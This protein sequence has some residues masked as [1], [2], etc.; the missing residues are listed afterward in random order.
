MTEPVVVGVSSYGARV[1]MVRWAAGEA[2][3]RGTELWLVT[4]HRDRHLPVDADRDA[5]LRTIADSWP[6]LTVRTEVAVGR[7]A[8]VLREF[9]E[10]AA[11]L[12]VGADDVSPFTEAITGSVPGDLL[13][14]AP[15]PLAVVPRREWTT[16]ASTPVVVALDGQET[17]QAALAYAFAAADRCDSPLTVLRFLA[18]GTAEPADRTLMGFRGLYHG[19]R[20]TTEVSHADPA[21]ELVA[22]SRNAAQLVLGSRGRGRLTSGLFGSVSRTLIRKAGCPVVVGRAPAAAGFRDPAAERIVR[23]YQERTP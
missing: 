4:A 2:A 22:A 18:P 15:C 10:D 20:V 3:R 19:V 5:V 11:L 17:S 12:V 9:A 6:D 16:P 13:T 8:P 7:P 21:E 23:Q 1:P 14:T